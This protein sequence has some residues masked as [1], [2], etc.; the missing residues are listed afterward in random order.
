MLSTVRN[1]YYL[2]DSV[3][4]IL[5]RLTF[6]AARHSRGSWNPGAEEWIPGRGLRP[7][8]E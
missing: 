1:N 7:C 4:G 2:A 5:L 6:V 8:P 3:E